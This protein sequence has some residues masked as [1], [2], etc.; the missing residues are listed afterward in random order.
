[1]GSFFSNHIVFNNW[2]ELLVMP[3]WLS[4]YILLGASYLFKLSMR[5]FC[6]VTEMILKRLLCCFS[7]Y[8]YI[9]RITVVRQLLNTFIVIKY[10]YMVIC[11][12]ATSPLT[13]WKSC[14]PFR[15]IDRSCLLTT[16]SL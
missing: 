16:C 6:I 10:V 15:V 3:L 9:I 4:C 2:I 1:M 11:W 7:I 5:A 8:M 12:L 13:F 14:Y